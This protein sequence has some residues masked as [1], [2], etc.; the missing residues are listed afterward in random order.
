MNK[1]ALIVDDSNTARQMLSGKL[2]KYGIAVDTRESAVAAIDYLYENAP[3]AIFM[4]YEMPGM[5]GFQALKVIKSNPNTAVIPVMMYTSKAGGLEL[6]QA[7]ALG[8]VGILPKQLEPQDLEGV[9]QSLH[10]MPEQESLVH[11]FKD[12]ELD[13]VHRIRRQDN[14][15]P[16][17]GHERRKAAPVEPVTLPL[18][19]FQD[20]VSGQ[21]PLKRF[22]RHEQ[23]QTEA[24]IQEKMDKHFAE[25]QSG[26]YELEALHEASVMRGRRG[27]FLGFVGGLCLVACVS[28]IYYFLASSTPGLSGM[29]R[30][31]EPNEAIQGLIRSQNEKIEQLAL[32]FGNKDTVGSI[33]ASDSSSLPIRLVEW[34]ANQGAEYAFGQ[35]AFNDQRALWLTELVELLKEAGFRGAIE[36]RANHGN[37]CLQK[38][39][40][41]AFSLAE[42][43]LAIGECL[44]VADQ[45]RGYGWQNDQSVS[46]ANYLN[47]ESDRNGGEVEILLFSSGLNDP[48]VPYPAPY[49]LKTA[50][51]WNRIA[52]QNQRV[53]VSLYSSY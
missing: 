22:I 10:L 42:P 23:E 26:L 3:D 53:R 14:V 50:G 51:E 28:V 20:T 45:R 31:S 40:S 16:I 18:D 25:I 52:A 15:H 37:F 29:D 12:D 11:G 24:R 17:D 36:L 46:F 6:S 7:R 39:D 19:S 48:M 38:S 41:G 4:D 49:E 5:D 9:L 8:A 2:S 27:L 35:M 33:K 32:S 13:G 47:V 1:R 30:G 34:A 44:F 43:D 21:E